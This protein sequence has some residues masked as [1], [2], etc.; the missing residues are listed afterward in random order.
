MYKEVII[1]IVI[2][3]TIFIAN[4]VS[5][6]YTDKTIDKINNDLANIK[7]KLFDVLDGKA[8]HSQESMKDDVEKI[9]NEWED[10]YYLLAVYLEHDEL[11][12]VAKELISL[13]ASVEVE[14]YQDAI[15]DAERSIFALEHLKEKEVLNVDNFF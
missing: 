15:G 2:I 4:S 12:K 11:E 1:S 5:Q 9:L 13:K 7:E 6:G 3:V 14:E 10:K 8:K